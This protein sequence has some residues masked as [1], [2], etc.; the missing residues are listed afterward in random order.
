MIKRL[1]PYPSHEEL[2]AMYAA[3]HDHRM[4]G[5]GHD[6]RVEA[7]VRL[8]LDEIAERDYVADLSCGNGE[9]ARRITT[10]ATALGDYAPGYEIT[11]P[12]EETLLELDFAD[13]Y[14]CS[15]TLEHVDDP[16]HVL[17]MIYQRAR[18]LLLSTPLECWDDANGEHMWAWDREGVEH[19]AAKCGWEPQAF[20]SVDSRTYGEPYLY[21]IW[22][23]A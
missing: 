14:V 20:T 23:F 17:D 21:G 9:I 5:R 22:V 1:R 2:A 11:G 4:Y 16:E 19:L 12:L 15:E 7:T 10:R 18:T 3:P 6:E 13:V 8:A